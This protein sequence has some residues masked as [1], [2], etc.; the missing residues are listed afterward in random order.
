MMVET[1][2]SRSMRVMFSGGV[3]LSIGML[4]QPAFAQLSD[5][6]AAPVQRVEITGSNIRRV[7]S[8]TPSPVQVITSEDIKK[9]GYTTIAE[10]LQNITA[11]GQGSLS[12]LQSGASFAAGASGIALRGLNTSSTLVLVDGHR[13]APY[14]IPDNAQFSFTDISSIPFDAVDRVEVLKDGA[15]AVYGSD[16]IAGVVN[17]ILK[18][19]FKGTRVS[20]EGGGTQ[21]GGG[22]NFHASVIHGIGDLN[23][24]GYNAYAN[25]EVRHQNEISYASREGIGQWSTPNFTQ[26]GGNNRTAGVIGLNPLPVTASPYL[27]DPNVGSATGAYFQPGASCTTAQLNSAAGCPWIPHSQLAPETENINLIFSFAKKL[28]DGWT[29]NTKA[30]FFDSKTNVIGN[31]GSYPNY[32]VQ[33]TVY[34]GVGGGLTLSAHTPL[35]VV[36]PASF[37]ITIPANYTGNGLGV[38]AS[39]YGTNITAPRY[40]DKIDVRTTRLVADLDGS[41]GEWDIKASLGYI[42]N[43]AIQ[44]QTGAINL[45][46]FNN[47]INRTASPFNV[48]SNNN[49]AADMAAIYPSLYS[50]SESLLEFGELHASRSLMA[51]PGGD[52]GFS[53]GVAFLHRDLQTVEPNLVSNGTISGNLFYAAGQQND[54]SVYAEFVA[55]IT[56]TLEMDFDERFDNINTYGNSVTGK[57]AFKW[58]PANSFALRGSASTGFRAPNVA[59]SGNSGS[60]GFFGNTYDPVYCPGG[61]T[62]SGGKTT[63]PVGAAINVA[64]T[65]TCNYSPPIETAGN[66]ALRPERSVS[67]T[68]GAIIEPIKGWSTTIDTYKITVND[69]IENPTPNFNTLSPVRGSPITGQCS[70]DGTATN[71]TSCQVAPV[72]YYPQNYLNLNSTVVEGFEVGTGYKFNLAQFGKLKTELDWS[73]LMSYRLTQGGVVYQL[74]GTHGPSAISNDTGNPSDRVQAILT[75]EQGPL[76]VA[77]TF[78]W[79]SSFKITDPSGGQPDCATAAA[80][81]GWFGGSLPPKNYCRVASFLTA[82]LTGRYNVSKNWNIH[83][84]VGN[85]FNRQPPVDLETYGNLGIAANT[86][87]HSAGVYGRSYTIGT[88][89]SF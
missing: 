27:I 16:A 65:N 73:H 89:Y 30:S 72:L 14:A 21:E 63:Y 44:N 50:N 15:S 10:V 45:V 51:L 80:Y 69:Q 33:G 64:G 84:G 49:S 36:G 12:N 48:F 25:L 82:N 47:A 74:A 37:P 62:T 70:V 57:A 11:N 88:S 24:D 66:S 3:A 8:E 1:I 13:M 77:T 42:R 17:V 60:I 79:I 46:S 85:V 35:G 56:K 76:Q 59:E 26:Y 39:L 38:P 40:E 32:Y 53:T 58:T 7:D 18:K 28:G 19:D 67:L 43:N 71:T 2:L 78:N 23:E 81:D 31:Q 55:P 61:S 5:T 4:A 86:T 22:A 34:T 9:S 20:A 41:I 87:L 83:G 68:L 6:T 29:L 54:A 75:W 52:L